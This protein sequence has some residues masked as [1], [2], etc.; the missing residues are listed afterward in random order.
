M[1]GLV[2]RLPDHKNPRLPSP[3]VLFY[4]DAKRRV[5]GR[6]STEAST[7]PRGTFTAISSSP[8]FYPKGKSAARPENRRFSKRADTPIACI[9]T[10]KYPGVKTL[11]EKALV[12][13]AESTVTSGK[14]EG[15]P[16]TTAGHRSFQSFSLQ[17]PLGTGYADTSACTASITSSFASLSPL[18]VLT[19][20]TRSG[21]KE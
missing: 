9:P 15:R 20:A 5:G 11:L 21:M 1:P 6:E 2:P 8:S 17:E 7:T 12:T 14:E 4:S 10:F 16:R 3:G 19:R 13:V 18:L